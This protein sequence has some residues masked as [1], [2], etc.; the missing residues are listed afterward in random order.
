MEMSLYLFC[1]LCPFLQNSFTPTTH[2]FFIRISIIFKLTNS[3]TEVASNMLAFSMNRHLSFYLLSCRIILFYLSREK[4]RG[5]GSRY[6][7]LF[8][9]TIRT[10][11]YNYIYILLI[12]CRISKYEIRN[13]KQYCM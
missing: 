8:Y 11:S 13:I 12:N 5:R 10:R 9:I 6:I 7:I 4:K 1:E 3:T 2:T